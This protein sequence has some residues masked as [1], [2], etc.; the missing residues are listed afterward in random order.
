MKLRFFFFVEELG[1]INAMQ[2]DNTNEQIIYSDSNFKI[3][4][5][6]RVQEGRTSFT[7][8]QLLTL[9]KGLFR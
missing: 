5:R 6:G 7:K 3:S 1:P 4:F 9:E 2:P 8:E